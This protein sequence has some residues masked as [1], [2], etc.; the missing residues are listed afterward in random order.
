MFF[1]ESY[2]FSL[3]ND[4]FEFYDYQMVSLDVIILLY[5]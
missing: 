4:Y 3:G 5:Y 2:L 1:I